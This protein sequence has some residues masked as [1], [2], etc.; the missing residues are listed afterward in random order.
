MA[1][2]SRD[3]IETLLIMLTKA[4]LL[5]LSI[6]YVEDAGSLSVPSKPNILYILADDMGQWAAGCYGNDEIITPNLDKLASEGVRFDNAYCNTP[7]CSASRAS[8]F[9]GRLPSQHG[10]HDWLSG[11]NGCGQ[12]ADNYMVEET[13]YT[14]VLAKSGYVCAMTGKYHLGNSPV[15]QH[16]FTHWF[17]H[18]SGGGSYIKPPVVKDGKCVVMDE[19]VTDLFT[20]D[21]IQ[22]LTEEWDRKTPFYLSVHYTSPHS[23]YTGSDGRADSM[24]P[25]KYV[26][27]YANCSFHSL[28]QEPI[29]PH[30]QHLDGGLTKG[31]LGNRQC[32]LG[33]FAA[34]TA[35][36]ANIGRL[37]DTLQKLSID[38]DTLVVFSSDHGFNAGQHGLWGKGNAAYPQNMFDTSLR[39]PFI[40][41]HKGTIPPGVEK[42]I[43]QVID[44]APTL[45]EYAGNL[46]LPK[47]T[48]NPGIS[49]APA[50]LDPS[51]RNQSVDRGIYGE[52]GRVRY[53][54]DSNYKYVNRVASLM[55]LFDLQNDPKEETN[56]VND[57][58]H[59]SAIHSR[60][61]AMREFFSF[62]ED[63]FLSGWFLPVTGTGQ[64]RPVLYNATGM[65][66][67][68]AFGQVR[69][70]G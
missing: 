51:K 47:K 5:I 66:T 21:A 35:M 27:M 48:N 52:Y 24:H 1:K 63:P 36:D 3:N 69:V 11:G 6:A 33:Y 44:V 34:V 17:V 31:C 58:T 10:I 29:N 61:I 22:F 37:M 57:K 19:Y 25:K 68:P 45:L 9:T 7:V 26:D 50:I 8:Y 67:T 60:E 15:P 2:E 59:Q 53:A 46:S 13:F 12:Q 62:Y 64:K 14:D 38:E 16:S 49:F 70:T 23:P 41:R 56:V 55:E 4:V 42:S 39:I 28:P 32:L 54:R 20:D 30:A 65:P 18:Q 40:V 43:V